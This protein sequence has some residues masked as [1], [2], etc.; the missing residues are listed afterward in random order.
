MFYTQLHTHFDVSLFVKKHCACVNRNSH[1]F[2][3]S[4]DRGGAMDAM[5]AVGHG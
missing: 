3:T 1:S 2:L 4:P 5:I